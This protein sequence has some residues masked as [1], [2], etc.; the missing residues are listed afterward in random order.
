LRADRNAGMVH[1]RMHWKGE[2]GM[3]DQGVRKCPECGI[4][5]PDDVIQCPE[6]GYPLRGTVTSK[7]SFLQLPSRT[8]KML[9]VVL[10]VLAFASAIVGVTQMTSKEYRISVENYEYCV[11]KRDEVSDLADSYKSGFFKDSYEDLAEMWQ[12]SADE[13]MAIIKSCRSKAI[14]F[15]VIGIVLFFFGVKFLIGGI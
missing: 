9:G 6:C 1:E 10:C 8:R 4:S 14:V 12:D 3:E 15:C 5:V 13:Q 2:N 7:K 11:E